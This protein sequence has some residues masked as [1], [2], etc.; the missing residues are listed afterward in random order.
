[1]RLFDDWLSQASPG[2]AKEVMTLGV[3]DGLHLGHRYLMSQVAERAKRLG[4]LS[5]ALTIEPHPLAILAPSAAPE[6]LTTFGQKAQALEGLGISSFGRIRFSQELCSVPAQAFLDDILAPRLNLAEILVGP[7]FRF[8]RGALGDFEL[9]EKWSQSRGVGLRAVPLQMAPLGE[10]YSSSRIRGLLKAGSVETAAALLGRPY[11]ISGTVERGLARGRGLGFPTAN[12]GGIPQ[13]IP[14]PG[15]YAVRAG[16]RGLSLPA[17]TS[18]GHNPTFSGQYLT[19]E[20]YVFDFSDDFYGEAMEIEFAG[21]LRGMVR[22]DSPEALV[23]QLRADELS[24]RKL[25]G[26]IGG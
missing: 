23:A 21:R 2:Q 9:L 7:D 3:F 6:L 11:R 20:T 14:G 13:L 22:F 26:L 4:L 8:G 18:V 25:L 16:L 1:M 19:V 10:T 17:M 24:A 12:L 15:V 5:L